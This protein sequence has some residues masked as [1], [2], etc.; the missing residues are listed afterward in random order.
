MGDEMSLDI[1][2]RRYR[3]NNSDQ[4]FSSCIS[5]FSGANWKKHKA[6]GVYIR[7]R[8]SIHFLLSQDRDK[9]TIDVWV[10][11]AFGVILPNKGNTIGLLDRRVINGVQEELTD[12][13]KKEGIDYLEESTIISGRSQSQ[14][15]VIVALLTG[16]VFI[17]YLS[18]WGV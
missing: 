4:I 9:I 3:L 16:I 8:T 1:E 10:V 18:I 14:Y 15:W 11:G 2:I 7:D 6:E 12:Y 17:L 5:F 13:L